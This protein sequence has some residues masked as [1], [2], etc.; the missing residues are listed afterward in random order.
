MKFSNILGVMATKDR[1]VHSVGSAQ[2]IRRLQPIH[3]SQLFLEVMMIIAVSIILV[4]AVV[5]VRI[6][7][8]EMEVEI[9]YLRTRRNE[10]LR[11]WADTQEQLSRL[12]DKIINNWEE[13]GVFFS[14]VKL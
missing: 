7:F 5:L 2:Q 8:Y 1:D 14:D 11:A 4:I 9:N 6:R 3:G 12:E 10:L 13:V